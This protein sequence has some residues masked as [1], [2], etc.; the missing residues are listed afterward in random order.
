MSGSTGAPGT[1]LCTSKLRSSVPPIAGVVV[2]R[3]PLTAA[4]R[5]NPSTAIEAA[6]NE[7]FPAPA[8]DR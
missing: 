5:K 3:G 4:A 6:A 8:P 2:W 7:R 1:S